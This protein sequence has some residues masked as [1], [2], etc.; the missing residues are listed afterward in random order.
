MLLKGVRNGGSFGTFVSCFNK[1]ISETEAFDTVAKGSNIAVE[2]PRSLPPV[3]PNLV[4]EGVFKIIICMGVCIN[5]PVTLTAVALLPCLNAV[6]Q[7]QASRRIQRRQK[8]QVL[9]QLQE[10]PCLRKMA[11]GNHHPHFQRRRTRVQQICSRC[12]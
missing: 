6:A 3:R 2:Y 11:R 1:A 12:W 8:Q 7:H 10:E 9:G 5:R 4:S